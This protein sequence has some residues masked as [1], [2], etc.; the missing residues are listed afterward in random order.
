MDLKDLTRPVRSAGPPAKAGPSAKDLA[1]RVL[2]EYA[3]LI[4]RD[5][6]LSVRRVLKL[7]DREAGKQHR[8][9][10]RD[11]PR[12]CTEADADLLVGVIG[13]DLERRGVA[14]FDWSHRD[15][16]EQQQHHERQ[17]D[18]VA[19]RTRQENAR[20]RVA[21]DVLG[22]LPNSGAVRMTAGR[23]ATDALDRAREQGKPELAL[24]RTFVTGVAKGHFAGEL[25]RH[26][27]DD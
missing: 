10:L 7:A 4:G 26:V 1:R 5:P 22:R 8:P 23:L 16:L 20:T 13:R 9:G 24:N 14:S 19:E 21:A 2:G 17:A 12:A 27:L 11:P 15:T 3:Q 18:V 25:G 6:G